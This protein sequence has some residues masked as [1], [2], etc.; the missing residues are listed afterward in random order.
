MTSDADTSTAYRIGNPQLPRACMWLM[1]VADYGLV[2]D[3]FEAVPEL[4]R[5]IGELQSKQ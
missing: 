4:E 5:Q 3:L 2:A 1:Q